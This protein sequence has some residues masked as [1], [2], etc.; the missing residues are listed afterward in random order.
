MKDL[1]ILVVHR[2]TAVARQLG[3]GGRRALVAE[4]LPTLPQLMGDGR[5]FSDWR[6]ATL[7]PLA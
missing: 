2:L 1:V 4:N 5:Q 7:L 3:P 6:N